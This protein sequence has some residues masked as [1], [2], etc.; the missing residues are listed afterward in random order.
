MYRSSPEY[1]LG[2][3]HGVMLTLA[4]VMMMFMALLLAMSDGGGPNHPVSAA[5]PLRLRI[6]TEM[7]VQ[8][9]T[10]RPSAATPNRLDA[11]RQW[12]ARFRRWAWHALHWLTPWLG[13]EA[14]RLLQAESQA[15][16]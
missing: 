16:E 2:Y 3:S 13:R 5:R 7:Q 14:I 15:V 4:L 11:R 12:P 8:H 1:M 10:I 6:A 9:F